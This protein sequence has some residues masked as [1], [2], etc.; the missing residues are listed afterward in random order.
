MQSYF[1]K[2]A[3]FKGIFVEEVKNR[4]LCKVRIKGTIT[5]CYV[6]SSCRLDNFLDLVGKEVLL[7][8]TKT[9]HARTPFSL[10]A[11]AYKNNYILLNSS[12]ANI[13]IGQNLNSRRFAKLGK[14]KTISRECNVDEYKCDFFIHDT[15]TLIEVKSIIS[16]KTTVG[17]PSIFSPR[18]IRQLKALKQYLEVGKPVCYIIVSLNPYTRSIFVDKT[19]PFY[20]VF[21]ECLSLGMTVLGVSCQ[22]VNEQL[23]IKKMLKVIM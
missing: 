18:A 1:M 7:F 23:S 11:V 3:I 8:P 21:E 14:R 16:T 12:I 9:P 13:L 4:F 2:E 19:T 6:P 15:E 20:T 17:F 22:I 10:L 5:L